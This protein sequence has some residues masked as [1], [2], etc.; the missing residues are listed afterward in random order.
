MN[1]NAPITLLN[2]IRKHGER[3]R[4]TSV[5]IGEDINIGT[6]KPSLVKGSVDGLLHVLTIEV[7]WGLHGGEGATRVD[8]ISDI[9]RDKGGQISY[10]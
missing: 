7:N 8:L 5:T 2:N 9:S 3:R 6:L 1:D 4:Q 10:G